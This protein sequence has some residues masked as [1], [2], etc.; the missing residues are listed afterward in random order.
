MR[1]P[2]PFGQLFRL[3]QFRAQHPGVVIGKHDGFDYWEAW[4]PAGSGGTVI[5]R[6]VLK[7][8]LDRLDELLGPE[9]RHGTGGPGEMT[10]TGDHQ[11]HGR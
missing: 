4:I 7:D 11:E 9:H 3:A 6:F 8:L 5:A 1:G 10:G 2:E